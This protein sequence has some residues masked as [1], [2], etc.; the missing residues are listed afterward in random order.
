MQTKQ[1]IHNDDE[2]RT[3]K[4]DGGTHTSGG[5]PLQAQEKD[6]ERQ[7]TTD[8]D[9]NPSYVTGYKLI[10]A[11]GALTL[12]AILINLDSSILSTATPTITDEFH[13]VKDIGWYVS[14][15]QLAVSA[16][17]P[18]T[19]KLFTYFSNKARLPW[20]YISFLVLFEAGS[21]I[22]GLAKSSPVFIAGRAVSGVG[23]SG[24]FSGSMI[25]VYGMV[26]AQTRPFMMGLMLAISQIG[27]IAG[28]LIGGS[29]TQYT[30]WR[31]CFWINLPV[32]G[33]ACLLLASVY[34]PEHIPKPT[35]R[36]VLTDRKILQ[37]FDVVGSNIL[38]GTVVQLLLALHF[39]GSEYP[40]SSPTVVGLLC[41]F[42]AA[43]I[44]FIG[45]EYRAGPNALI[46]L[47]LFLNR[48]LT[49]GALMNLCAS[50]LT[51]IATY[52][53]PIF[54]QSILGDS[55]MESGIHM[56]PSIL[57]SILFTVLSGTIGKTFSSLL[58][59]IRTETDMPAVSK[60]GYYLPWAIF[61][62]VITAV[63]CG[64]MSTWSVT[65]GTG[66]WIGYQILYGS[67][68]GL[69][70]QMAIV[71]IQTVLPPAH[72]AT[73]LTILVFIQGLG[74]SVLISIGNAVFDSTVA[75]EIEIHAPELD[76]RAI[77]KAGAT[78]FRSQVP[79]QS[80]ADVVKAWA[81]GYQRTMYIATGLS[82][83]MFLFACGLGLYDVRKKSDE[84]VPEGGEH[85]SDD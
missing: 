27:M 68:R 55:P 70:M 54:F 77:I 64:L 7:P 85:R 42:G 6:A 35:A 48:V 56:L 28:P 12:S 10:L 23:A 36:S 38:I 46:P 26:P 60:L 59:R 57:S 74:I 1:S 49:C 17:Q 19:G 41:G 63:G 50:G 5:R 76:P 62:A 25:I 34:I 11:I 31:W 58:L 18:M 69:G 13:S 24:L 15:Y 20:T 45:W 80:L 71:A 51:Y 39:G 21:L 44:L 81:V 73:A 16:L 47:E 3:K 79:P 52:F 72:V 30:T 53:I 8:N 22:C 14:S 66:K 9:G 40:W 2:A 29:L 82:V 32:G 83:G 67:G 78:A 43:A 61:A 33:L 4:K 84:L 65:T 75:S 37:T